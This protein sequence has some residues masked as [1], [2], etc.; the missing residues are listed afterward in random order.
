[1]AV[2]AVA[3]QRV[4]TLRMLWAD[5]AVEAFIDVCEHRGEWADKRLAV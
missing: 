2:A 4:G 1:M 3:S 5:S